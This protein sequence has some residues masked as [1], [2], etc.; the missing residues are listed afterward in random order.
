MLEKS[1]YDFTYKGCDIRTKNWEECMFIFGVMV[2]MVLG[3]PA[4]IMLMMI[5]DQI[6]RDLVDRMAK[7]VLLGIAVLSG[8]PMG[9][10]SLSYNLRL[11]RQLRNKNRK[12]NE[13]NS[14]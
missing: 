8:I 9:I 13:I 14:I 10:A 11:S 12:N 3:I 1:P 4:C 6:D 7:F 5:H 2:S